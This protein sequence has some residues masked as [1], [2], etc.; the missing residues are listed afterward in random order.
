[1]CF[2]KKKL[3]V[4]IKVNNIKTHRSYC[5]LFCTCNKK[6]FQNFVHPN[7]LSKSTARFTLSL[8]L[9]GSVCVRFFCRTVCATQKQNSKE[10]VKLHL[11]L[12]FTHTLSLCVNQQHIL[13][14]LQRDVICFLFFFFQVCRQE[15]QRQC[16][17][18]RMR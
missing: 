11:L 12:S 10:K 15:A 5:T 14:L 8:L 2:F 4:F 6:F 7:H 17:D 1:M 13:Y 16:P 9:G 18:Q 3:H